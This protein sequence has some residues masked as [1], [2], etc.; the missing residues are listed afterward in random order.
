MKVLRLLWN[1]F[2]RT[3]IHDRRGTWA[4]IGAAAIGGGLGLAG[5]FLGGGGDDQERETFMPKVDFLTPPAAQWR[6]AP[7]P[8]QYAEFPESEQARK[9]WFGKM[10]QWG[11]EPG[12]GA[13]GPDWGDIWEQSQQRVKDYYWGGP[14]GQPGLAGELGTNAHRPWRR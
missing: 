12:Y 11:G 10:E 8:E 14:G 1:H 3:V 6:G 7:S 9:M 13:I 5:S 4:M 2:S